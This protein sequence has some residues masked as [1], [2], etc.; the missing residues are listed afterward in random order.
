MKWIADLQELLDKTRNEIECNPTE[1]E[2]LKTV[3]ATISPE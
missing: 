2:L 3:L 1:N